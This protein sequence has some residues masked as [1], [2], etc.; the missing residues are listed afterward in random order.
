MSQ[1]ID[2]TKTEPRIT[3]LRNVA[4]A[5]LGLF[6]AME[7]IT[8]GLPVLFEL[9]RPSVPEFMFISAEAHA[10]SF[11][12]GVLLGGGTALATS[13]ILN[14]QLL[15]TNVVTMKRWQSNLLQ[16]GFF[17][18]W[19]MVPYLL[20]TRCT[21]LWTE[22]IR[23]NSDSSA[24]GQCWSALHSTRTIGDGFIFGLLVC[25]SLWATVTEVKRH[26]QVM[27]KIETGGKPVVSK[28]TM[29]KLAV[30][31]CFLGFLIYVFYEVLTLQ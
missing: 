8:R 5:L 10:V 12:A 7:L 17:T 21:S 16:V 2:I 11:V 20:S 23:L 27:L 25:I 18:I 29:G 6:A 3:R 30:A 26:E 19:A 1:V 9:I 22:A 13:R 31:L 14:R 4:L 28:W 24:V 15:L